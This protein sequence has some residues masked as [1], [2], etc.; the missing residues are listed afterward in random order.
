MA[1]ANLTAAKTAK[2]DEFYTRIEDIENELGHY[3]QHFKD[4]TVLCNCDDPTYSNFWKYFFLNFE[5][6]GLRKLISTH[7]DRV[8]STYK[9]EYD[10]QGDPVVIPLESNGDFASAECVRL[11]EESDIVI[12]NPPFS[13]FRKYVKQLMDYQKKFLIIGS[14]NAITYKEFFPYLKDNMVWKGFNHVHEFLQPDGSI[15]KFGNICWFTNLDISKRHE[16]LILYKQYSPEEY[17][18]Y[19]NYDA[20]NVDRVADIPMD[21]DGVMGVPITFMDKYNPEQ[22]EIIGADGYDG[23]PFTKKYSAKEKVVNGVH[24]ASKTGA[25]GCVI[26][27]DSYG[28]GTY[29]DVGYPVKAVYK[30]IFIKKKRTGKVG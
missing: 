2:N 15:K 24:M 19:D 20:I 1:N 28:K 16:D 27:M 22:F 25:L 18:T 17:P 13:E 4:A 5:A 29:F 9:M 6:M 8:N 7:Y 11:L 23:T 12:T 3:W 14:E 26:R 30:R 10:G 21:Y